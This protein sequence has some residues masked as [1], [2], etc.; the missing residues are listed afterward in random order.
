MDLSREEFLEMRALIHRLCGLVVPDE[1]EYLIRQ[2]L[3][4]VVS[5]FGRASF[6]DFIAALS[7]L[8][9][10]H[11]R[12]RII[13]EITTN[14]TSFFR[15]GHPFLAIEK[16]ALPDLCRRI[17]ER[18]ARSHPRRGPKA[19]IWSTAASTGQEPYSLSILVH[20][21]C[22]LH[23]EERVEPTDFSILATDI[24]AKVLAQAMAGE[25]SKWDLQRGL[26][27]ERI[28]NFF[29]ECDGKW[30]VQEALRD[31][32][33]F[34][35]VNLMESIEQLGAFDLILC[36]NI[37]IYFDVDSRRRICEQLAQMLNPDG[38]LV[39]GSTENLYGVTDVFRSRQCDG[40]IFYLRPDE[41]EPLSGTG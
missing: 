17:R 23:P 9:A 41:R 30:V 4:P 31:I 19:T 36:R 37:L 27:T 13:E 33:E 5:E 18:R 21:Y 8:D 14:E 6:A 2:R 15:D 22:R 38:V 39:L 32:V 1:K 24:S 29:R 10:D 20:E 28:N 34:R 7:H 11:L 40:T 26:N 25:Y 12:N 16:N 3:G 35:R